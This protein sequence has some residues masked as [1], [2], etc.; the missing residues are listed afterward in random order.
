MD[1][2]ISLIRQSGRPVGIY[3]ELKDPEWINSMDIVR[4]SSRRF[5]DIFLEVLMRY[6]FCY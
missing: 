3:P 1:E 6:Y 5:E 4:A 2:Y